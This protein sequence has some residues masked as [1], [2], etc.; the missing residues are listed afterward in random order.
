MSDS[1]F[2]SQVLNAALEEDHRRQEAI[3]TAR[4][5][6]RE[7]RDAAEYLL[8]ALRQTMPLVRAGYCYTTEGDAA[9]RVAEAAIRYAAER[10]IK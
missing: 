9:S 1:N 7:A 5:R 10:G 2:L 6:E 8:V 4:S 3:R